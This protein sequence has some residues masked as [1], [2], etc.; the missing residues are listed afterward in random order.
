[1]GG[2]LRKVWGWTCSLAKRKEKKTCFCWEKATFLT[3]TYFYLQKGRTPSCAAKGLF[4]F[5]VNYEAST[6][7]SGK[8]GMA[9][10]EQ[11]VSGGASTRKG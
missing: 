9:R 4:C 11:N 1:M 5:R 7:A 10:F 6:L 2:T 8:R 3:S